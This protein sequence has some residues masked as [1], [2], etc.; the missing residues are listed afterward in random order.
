MPDLFG[1]GVAGKLAIRNQSM[2]I[3]DFIDQC[4][5]DGNCYMVG[6]Y[7]T[8]ASGGTID[9]TMQ[10]PDTTKWIH[11]LYRG[12][13]SSSATIDFYENV[14][15]VS[16]GSALPM[17]NKNRNSANA[18]GAVVLINPTSTLG[19][20]IDGFKYGSDGGL[21]GRILKMTLKQNTTYLWRIV[22]QAADNSFSFHGVW[23]EFVLENSE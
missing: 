3:L 18:S 6:G 8:I 5:N 17:I 11:I 12:E 10:T 22:S 20:R 19:D 21:P 4:I 15:N 23:G 13:L 7:T 1:P 14:T 2:Q 16:G 9:I